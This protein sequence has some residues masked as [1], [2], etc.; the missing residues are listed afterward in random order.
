ML[1]DTSMDALI[2]AFEAGFASAD[3]SSAMSASCPF[4]DA[5]EIRRTAWRDGAAFRNSQ[6][7]QRLHSRGPL[8]SMAVH[9]SFASPIRG[10]RSFARTAV[11]YGIHLK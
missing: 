6:R 10:A 4:G 5:D 8:V 3:V 9:G 11:S 7:L 1:L 2:D